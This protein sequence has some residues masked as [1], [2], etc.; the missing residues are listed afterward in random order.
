MKQPFNK[1][2]T[3]QKRSERSDRIINRRRWKDFILYYWDEGLSYRELA[4]ECGLS[5]STVGRIIN[6]FKSKQKV[7]GKR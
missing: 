7:K 5:I 6:E 2:L 1:N 3:K 4:M